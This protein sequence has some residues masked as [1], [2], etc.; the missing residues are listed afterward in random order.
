MTI[1]VRLVSV[2]PYDSLSDLDGNE[3][4]HIRDE[5]KPILLELADEAE[6]SVANAGVIANNWAA[7]QL[8]HTTVERRRR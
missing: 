5:A 4:T 2:F 7:R 3:L 6:L 8:Q 1:P